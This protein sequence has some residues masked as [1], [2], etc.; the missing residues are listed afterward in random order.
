MSARYIIRLDDASEYMDHSKWDPFFELFDK[1][2]IKPIIAIIPFNRDPKMT[3]KKPDENFW[4]RARNW[5]MRDYRIAMHGYEHMYSNLN[6][7]IIGLNKYSEFA[8][9]PFEKQMEMIGK[10]YNKFEDEKLKPDIFVAPAHSFDRNTL[11]AL[12]TIGKINCLSDGF[13]VNPVIIDGLKWIPQQLWGPEK[14]SKGVWTICFH[15]ETSDNSVVNSLDFFLKDNFESFEDPY[16][17]E[18]HKRKFEDFVY[19]MYMKFYMK[20]RSV[21]KSI[22]K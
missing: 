21:F 5:Q 13:F 3:N 14:K 10:A 19:S 15:P 6:G 20:V 22:R 18:F 2:K 12:K 16:S 11:K 17:L 4:D 9:V 8:G 1:Y 7:G